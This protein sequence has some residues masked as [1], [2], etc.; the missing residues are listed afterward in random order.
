MNK[1]RK[2]KKNKKKTQLPLYFKS[3][4]IDDAKKMEKSEKVFIL[5]PYRENKEKERGVQLKEFAKVFGSNTNPWNKFHTLV[6]EQSDDGRKFNRGALLNIGAKIAGTMGASSLI[7]HDVDL[8]P[9]EL[10][11]P[12]YF[13][14]PTMPI[15]IGSVWRTKYDYERFLGGIL[16]ISINDFSKVNGYPNNFFGWGGEDDVLTD[17]MLKKKI[18]TFYRPDFINKGITELKHTHVGDNPELT[19]KDKVY[20]RIKDD[21]TIGMFQTK[22]RKIGTE[23]LGNNVWKIS[24]E[25]K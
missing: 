10:I 19:V 3:I 17:R 18:D 22:Y 20:K 6:I 1:T 8:I 13:A 21:G 15:H 14:Y 5:V 7:L 4:S 2:T 12:Y 9:D 24:V 11:L 25:L 16:H 23:I